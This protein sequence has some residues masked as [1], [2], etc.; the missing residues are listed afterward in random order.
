MYFILTEIYICLVSFLS[1]IIYS[2]KNQNNKTFSYI[3]LLFTIIIFFLILDSNFEISL[4]IYIFNFNLKLNSMI[5]FIK[6]VII[7]FLFNYIY[8][9]KDYFIFEKVYIKEFLLVIWLCIV[10]VFFMIMSNEF[11]LLYLALELQ[12]LVL[13]IIA[14]LRRQRSLS[15]EAGIKYYIM[16]SFSSGLLLYGIIML[17][18]F[19]GTLDFI[20][21]SYLIKDV[22]Y[23]N[24]NYLIYFFLFIFFGLLFK[25]GAAPLHWWL[26][27]IYEGASVVVTLFFTIVPKLALV[28]VFLKL[29]IYIIY[30]LNYFF[31]SLFFFF[32]IFSLIFGFI[33]SLYQKKIIKFLAY[34]SIFNTAFFLACFA[35]G[36]YFSLIS[37]LYFFLPYIFTLLGIFF[38]LISYRKLNFEK[39]TLLWDFSIL[40]NSNYI[41]GFVFSFFFF[42]LAGIPPLSGFFSKFFILLSLIL[43]EYYFLFFILIIFSVISSFYYFRVVRFVFFSNILEYTFLKSYL[44]TIFLTFYFYFTLFFFIFY[45]YFFLLLCNLDFFFFYG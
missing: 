20:E 16:G 45:D 7:A 3:M 9:A 33:F 19:T 31:N 13:Y 30:Y 24:I 21:I 27:E 23:I 10:A 42:S 35:N 8:L 43:N 37:V 26:P 34:S 2:L 17:F 32:C 4:N 36:T 25:L 29:Y 6:L 41:L 38:V 39:F 5:I 40:G 28:V 12:N 18:S 44:N 1:L 11:F 22:N 15:V 14:C